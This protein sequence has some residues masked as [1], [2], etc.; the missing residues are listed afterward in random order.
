[1]SD[2]NLNSITVIK[3]WHFFISQ[4]IIFATFIG[5][6]V[7]G[8]EYLDIKYDKAYYQKSDGTQLNDSVA[9]LT[10]IVSYLKEYTINAD[11][12]NSAIS[13]TSFKQ[14]HPENSRYDSRKIGKMVG[15]VE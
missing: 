3:S 5:F 7:K 11:T 15:K 12:F 1:M 9:K 2:K 4:I 10:E 8:M 14:G 6:L 13:G